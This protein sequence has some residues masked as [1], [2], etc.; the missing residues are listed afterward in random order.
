MKKNVCHRTEQR[1]I[2]K[3]IDQRHSR[4]KHAYVPKADILNTTEINLRRKK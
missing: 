4:L 1:T 2:D 3:S